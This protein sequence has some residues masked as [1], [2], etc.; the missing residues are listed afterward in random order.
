VAVNFANTN[1]YFV[2]PNNVGEKVA[3]NLPVTLRNISWLKP[4]FGV[5]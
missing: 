4:L 1:F 5:N 2:F 3:Y